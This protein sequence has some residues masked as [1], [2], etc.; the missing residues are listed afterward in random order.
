[1]E[2]FV[3]TSGWYYDW[4]EEKTLDWF[5]ANSGLNAIELNASFYRFPFPNQV[6]AWARKGECLSWV[7]K[8]H[9]LITHQFKFNKDAVTVWK[10][11]ANLFTPL[12]GLV[13]FYLFQ[14]PRSQR[15]MSAILEFADRI[16]LGRRFALE[17][18]NKEI[19][20]DD[21]LCQ[22]LQK[23]V[24]LVSIDSPDFHFRIFPADIIYLRMH[25]RTSWYQ[26]N[27]SKKELKEAVALITSAQPKSA[28]IFFNNNHDM[29]KNARMM[30]GFL[31][32]D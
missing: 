2:T 11:F 26:Y 1:M 25:G 12:D 23:K 29:L 18:R 13:D 7:V 4:N 24:T 17:L 22:A 16:Q 5:I 28:Y 3:G 6:R 27:Y 20:E 19:L 8:V 15:N 30:M 14:V 10:R 9:R 21:A 32:R 31:S